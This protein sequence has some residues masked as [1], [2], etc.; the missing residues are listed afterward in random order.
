M[1]KKKI[2]ILGAGFA[3]INTYVSLVKKL[4][5]NEADILFINKTNYFLFTPML[6]ELATGGLG[7]H[8]VVESVRQIIHGT[9]ADILVTQVG[10]IDF[11]KKTVQVTGGRVSYDYLVIALG[12]TTNFCDIPGVEQN[13]FVL[14]DLAD[15]IRLRNNFI[16]T[17]E[18]ASHIADQEKRKK[19]LS[20][21]VVGAG[22]TGVELVTEMADLFFETFRKYYRGHISPG[23]ISIIL[24]NKG[25]DVLT[26]FDRSMQQRALRVIIEKGITVMLNKDVSSITKSAVLFTDGSFLDA[27]CVIWTAGVKPHSISFLQ[28]VE[29]DRSGR[30]VV[31]EYLRVRNAEHVFALGDA[32]SFMGADGRPLPMLAQVATQQGPIAGHNIVAHIRKMPFKRFEYHSKGSLVSLGQ[33]QGVGKIGGILWTGPI[34]WLIWRIVYLFNFASVPK[35]L[36]IAISWIINMFYPRDITKP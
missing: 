33:W 15:A 25:P 3:G 7:D 20:F 18:K 2:V 12:A 34:S 9:C 10:E 24:I 28:P 8:E 27:S 31:D 1:E 29:L 16:S 36:K 35:R 32:A 22:A 4:Q 13:S 19:M 21:V 30:I 26:G 5:K 17:F 11:E 23:D 6:H 14:K